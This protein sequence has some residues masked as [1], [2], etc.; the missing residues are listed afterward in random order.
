MTSYTKPMLATLEDLVDELLLE[1]L[2]YVSIRNR[3]DIDFKTW[4]GAD[5]IESC[6][7]MLHSLSLV[8]RKLHRVANPVLYSVLTYGGVARHRRDFLRTAVRKPELAALVKEVRFSYFDWSA[9]NSGIPPDY[10]DVLEAAKL[11]DLGTEEHI[12]PKFQNSLREGFNDSDVALLFSRLPNLEILEFEVDETWFHTWRWL[13]RLVRRAVE[14]GTGPF[15]SLSHLKARYGNEN[16]S[17]FNP[18]FIQD[19]VALPSL[20]NIEVSGAWC[21]ER[22]GDRPLSLPSNSNIHA[23]SFWKSGLSN[24][25]I[26]CALEAF[27][28]LKT[29]CYDWGTYATCSSQDYPEGIRNALSIRQDT[30][31]HIHLLMLAD[32]SDFCMAALRA[33]N[34]FLPFGSFKNFS[35]LKCL[36]VS[37][38]LLMGA[39]YNHFGIMTPMSERESSFASMVDI[40]PPSLETLRVGSKRTGNR[41]AQADYRVRFFGELLRRGGC[42]PNLRRLE[43]VI[44][45]G[46]E[47][48][49]K[50]GFYEMY[51][52]S[53]ERI[54]ELSRDSNVKFQVIS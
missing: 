37:D 14:R 24:D 7:S 41:Q 35:R 36:E 44:H 39:T 6:V 16:Q 10:A 52:Q 8:T 49:E 53:I 50:D 1:I 51:V 4:D 32:G 26:R 12:R 28:G 11:V 9:D 30:L 40:F 22:D 34:N 3:Y 2:D 43:L 13:L 17:G 18:L 20:M 21:D 25:F 27:S 48:D 31:E 29:F 33:D 5:E 45:G 23:L 46:D 47:E 54:K 42:L 15:C 19:W 38:F